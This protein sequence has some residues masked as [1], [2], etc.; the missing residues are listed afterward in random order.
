MELDKQK[1]LNRDIYRVGSTYAG[2]ELVHFCKNLNVKDNL[3]LPC[4]NHTLGEVLFWKF[5]VPIILKVQ[6]S[7]GCKYIFLFAADSTENELLITYYR[8]TLKF[9]QA[10][11]ISTSKPI[12]DFNCMFMCQSLSDLKENQKQCFENF[13]PDP[14]DQIV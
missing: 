6:D 2:I 8:E 4:L 1:E 12:Y 13:N 11:D 10:E 7:I 3:T 5:I 9:R 14:D